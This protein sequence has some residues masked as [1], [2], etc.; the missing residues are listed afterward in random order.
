MVYVDKYKNIKVYI[1]SDGA[2]IVRI[3]YIKLFTVD[4]VDCFIFL[5]TVHYTTH[6]WNETC[7]ISF[8]SAFR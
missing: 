1:Y 2:V 5:S 3:K 6:S 7:L 8:S 4:D